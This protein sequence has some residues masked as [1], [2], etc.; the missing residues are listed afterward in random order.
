[1]SKYCAG[2]FTYPDHFTEEEAFI[3]VLKVKVEELKPCVLMP[4]HDESV[5][6]MRHRKEFPKDLIIPISKVRRCC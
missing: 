2:S 5:V 3:H 1:M 6:I 4:T